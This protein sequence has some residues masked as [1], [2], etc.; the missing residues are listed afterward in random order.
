MQGL[1][2]FFVPTRAD[3]GN[4]KLGVTYATL[5]SRTDL[6]QTKAEGQL[7]N[8]RYGVKM[9]HNGTPMVSGP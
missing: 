3:R 1:S 9:P 4:I 2:M 5:F 8:A 7:R 6:L